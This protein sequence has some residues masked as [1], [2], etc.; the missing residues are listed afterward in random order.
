MEGYMTYEPWRRVLADEAGASVAEAAAELL[1][2]N[3]RSESAKL[4]K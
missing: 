3:E 1:R 4:G 2:S